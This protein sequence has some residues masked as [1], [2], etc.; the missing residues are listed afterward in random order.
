MA[1]SRTNPSPRYKELMTLYKQMHLEGDK[2]TGSKPE[3]VFPGRSLFPQLE[4]IKALIDGAGAN[5]IL[6]YGS[7]KGL[8]YRVQDITLPS[9]LKMNNIPEY[10]AVQEIRCYDPAYEPFSNYPN[11]K[12]DGVICTDVLEHCPEPDMG[13]IV[14]ELFAFANRFVY[15]N[16]AC[17]PAKRILPNGENA[18]CTIKEPEWWR[19]LLIKTCSNHPQVFFEF[20]VQHND[21][22]NRRVETCFSNVPRN[23]AAAG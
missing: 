10:F 6:D 1:F 2:L 22:E 14:N 13:W 21:A 11:K 5:S 3:E 23:Q 12:Y 18:H 17:Y 19:Q 7:G 16:V 15:A 8:Q 9:G 20:W 4:R